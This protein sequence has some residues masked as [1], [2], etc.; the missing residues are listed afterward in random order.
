M[1]K[2][3][4]IFRQVSSFLPTDDDFELEIDVLEQCYFH[5]REQ[6]LFYFLLY[7]KSNF[8]P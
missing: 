4:W 7:L 1:R 3:I 6:S 2:W 8:N 5:V